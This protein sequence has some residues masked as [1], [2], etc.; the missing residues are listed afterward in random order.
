MGHLRG[1]CLGDLLCLGDGVRFDWW[2]RCI[3]GVSHDAG[4]SSSEWSEPGGSWS[5][6]FGSHLRYSLNMSKSI[7]AK[8]KKRGRPAT[9]K[10]PMVGFRFPAPMIEAIREFAAAEGVSRSEAARRLVELG[11]KARPAK[12]RE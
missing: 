3:V 6:P 8:P 1:H 5:L 9:G 2:F 11:L 12:R 10:D 7:K 4:I